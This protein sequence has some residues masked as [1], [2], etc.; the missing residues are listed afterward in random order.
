MSLKT[1]KIYLYY[2]DLRRC[3]LTE[4]E[5]KSHLNED[6]QRRFSAYK[7][8]ARKRQFGVGRWAIKMGL[9]CIYGLPVSHRYELHE[10]RLWIESAQ[11]REFS[12]SISHSGQYV[13]VLIASAGCAIGVDVEQHKNRNYSELLERF[14]TVNECELVASSDV[15]GQTFYRLWTAK[16]AL[17]KASQK[18]LGEISREDMSACFL[19][20]DCQVG[21]HYYYFRLL[22]E[23]SYSLSLVC[24][25]QFVLEQQELLYSSSPS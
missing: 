4:A 1:E 17:L 8:T 18:S 25:K 24:N 5:L 6:D 19:S 14:A 21:G 15:P 23:E 20:T 13:A 10:H 9:Q 12:V 2:C 7:N 3:V 22:G 11:L 16:E